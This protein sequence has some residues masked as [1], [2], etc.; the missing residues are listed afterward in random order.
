[1]AGYQVTSSEVLAWAATCTDSNVLDAVLAAIPLIAKDP[2]SPPAMPVP[3]KRQPI[4]TWPVDGTYLAI[5][6]LVAEQFHTVRIIRIGE[7]EM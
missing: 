6:Y 3:G 7:P 4:Y 1:M 5:T 2:H